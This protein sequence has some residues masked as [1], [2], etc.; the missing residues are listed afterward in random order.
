MWPCLAV[1]EHAF[2]FIHVLVQGRL[3]LLRLSVVLQDALLTWF[4][5]TAT[6]GR[7]TSVKA[8]LCGRLLLGVTVALGWL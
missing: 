5:V 8:I 4:L 2:R 6:L 1:V 3:W 7:L